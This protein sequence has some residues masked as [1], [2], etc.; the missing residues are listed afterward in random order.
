MDLDASAV[1]VLCAATLTAQQMQPV[2]AALWFLVQLRGSFVETA[3]FC[4]R[5][6]ACFIS[7]VGC[8]GPLIWVQ[9]CPRGGKDF[10]FFEF[11]V[12]Q[13]ADLPNSG[14]PSRATKMLN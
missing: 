8:H 12:L 6:R 11:I 13:R 5:T 3:S 14:A 2:N 4:N 10:S 1:A 9:C 7:Y